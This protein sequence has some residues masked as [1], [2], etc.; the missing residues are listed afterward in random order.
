MIVA[1]ISFN[2]F[3][4]WATHTKTPPVIRTFISQALTGKDV[5]EPNAVAAAGEEFKRRYGGVF[6]GRYV[7]FEPQDRLGQST[8]RGG[9][10]G[11]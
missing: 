9:G 8:G 11:W 5:E 1:P 7:Y 6:D 3:V 2:F 4:K 10:A